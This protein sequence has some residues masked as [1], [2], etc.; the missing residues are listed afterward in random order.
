MLLALQIQLNLYDPSVLPV[1]IGIGGDGDYPRHRGVKPIVRIR[2]KAERELDDVLELVETVSDANR[3]SEN[4]KTIKAA[5]AS[6]QK[7]EAPEPYA[8]AIQAIQ[9][10]LVKVSRKTAKHEGLQAATATIAGD[11]DA[12]IAK[13][14]RR[15]K[16]QMREEE[17]VVIWVLNTI[18]NPSMPLA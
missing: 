8:P 4:K 13:M 2:P 10:A 16:R 12:L 3:V 9:K 11:L 17:E 14:Q 5:I 18:N 7:I 15:R 6:I 1:V